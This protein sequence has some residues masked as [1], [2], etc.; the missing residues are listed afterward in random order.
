MSERDDL[1][2]RLGYALEAVRAQAARL[3]TPDD[4]RPARTSALRGDGGPRRPRRSG[5]DAPPAE[6]GSAA[7]DAVLSAGVSAV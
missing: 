1:W 6:R 7:F 3:G 5:S 2:Y 4:G